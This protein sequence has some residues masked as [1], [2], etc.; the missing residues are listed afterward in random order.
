[1]VDL[2]ELSRRVTFLIRELEEASDEENPVD[3]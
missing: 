3:V 2:V 1:V